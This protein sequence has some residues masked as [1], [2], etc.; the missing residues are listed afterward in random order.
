MRETYD[1]CG[2]FPTGRHYAGIADKLTAAFETK[3]LSRELDASSDWR[4]AKLVAIDLETTGLKAEND[5]VLEVGIAYFVNGKFTEHRNWLVNP[6]IPVPA[7]A[8]AVHQIKDEELAEA[9]FFG[10][11]L[12]EFCDAIKGHIPIAYNAAFDRG[13]LIAEIKRLGPAAPAVASLPAALQPQVAWID[14]L[15][16]ARELQRSEKSKKLSD[17][18]ARLGIELRDAHRAAGDAEATGKVLLA[19][20]PQM[21]STYGELIGLQQQYA[22]RQELDLANWRK[23][24]S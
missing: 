4:K 20:A 19:L 10:Q 23:K 24:R 2:C 5:R 12:P 7:E 8:R 14:P 17:V 13:F 18:C 15:V 16:W 9:P 21:P 11:I 6:G 3:G 22:A 1:V